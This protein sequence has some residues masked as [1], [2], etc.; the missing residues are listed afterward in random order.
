MLY[1]LSYEGKGQ[2]TLPAGPENSGFPREPVN[3]F[4]AYIR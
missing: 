3:R 4:S 2:V 1:P